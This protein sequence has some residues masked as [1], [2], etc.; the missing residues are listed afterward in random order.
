[1]VVEE[2]EEEEES[3]L[4]HRKASIRFDREVDCILLLPLLLGR[5]LADLL[6]LNTP[7]PPL[8]FLHLN[9]SRIA[10][11]AAAALFSDQPVDAL[12]LDSEQSLSHLTL[13]TV[14]SSTMTVATTLV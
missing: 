13:L 3:H 11:S 10:A 6:R 7:P 1:M 12:N 5:P 4:R 9:N 2:E 8:L 14:M